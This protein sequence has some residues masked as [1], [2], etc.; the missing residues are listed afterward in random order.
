[1]L[2]MTR[3]KRILA[4]LPVASVFL[5]G[6]PYGSTLPAALASINSTAGSAVPLCDQCCDGAL[7]RCL[8]D[9]SCGLACPQLPALPSMAPA[10]W[11]A[12]SA[13]PVPLPVSDLAGTVP[14]PNPP[15]PRA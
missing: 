2:A 4:M 15:P 12:G 3:A 14:R 9:A 7:P 5:A 8:L 10:S 11:T 6:G 1:M 13:P